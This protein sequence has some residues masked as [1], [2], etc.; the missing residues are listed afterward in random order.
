LEKKGVLREKGFILTHGLRVQ[1]PYWE[2]L[3]DRSLRPL[4]L[5]PSTQDPSL[6]NVLTTF[7]MGLS[8]LI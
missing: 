4:V 7:R 5:V 2:E 1:P 3:G 6:G 8:A